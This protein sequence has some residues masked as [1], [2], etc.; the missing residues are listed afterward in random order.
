MSA[1]LEDGATLSLIASCPR[2]LAD[3][4]V[5]ELAAAGGE[6]IRERATGATFQG[7]LECAYR[8]CMHSRTANRLFLEV[9]SF[10]CGHRGRVLCGGQTD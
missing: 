2:G 5:Q 6:G 10:P 7:T 1:P 4:L 3:L 8:V 9:A